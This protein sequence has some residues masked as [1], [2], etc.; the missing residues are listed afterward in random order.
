LSIILL[1]LV[2][3]WWK[4]LL[5]F[6]ST[7]TLTSDTSD[8]SVEEEEWDSSL[9]LVEGGY[10]IHCNTIGF[11]LIILTFWLLTSIS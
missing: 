5:L 1:F 9:V 11:S 10:Y 6:L 2:S 7:D 8:R 4:A 3:L